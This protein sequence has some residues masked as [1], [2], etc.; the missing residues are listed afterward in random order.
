MPVLLISSGATM[1][2]KV[3][4]FTEERLKGGRSSVDR[5]TADSSTTKSVIEGEKNAGTGQLKTNR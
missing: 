2:F 4:R 1:T 3:D 5:S